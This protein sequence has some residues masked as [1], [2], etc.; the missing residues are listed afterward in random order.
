MCFQQL[1]FRRI[2]ESLAQRFQLVAHQ[3]NK[4][5]KRKTFLTFIVHRYIYL[6]CGGSKTRMWNI[7]V[8]FTYVAIWHDLNLNLLLWAW[9]ICFCLA[10][11][12]FVKN[13]VK[14]PKF[15]KYTQTHYWKYICAVAGG[16]YNMW[17]QF[18]NTIGFGMGYQTFLFFIS[19]A[20]SSLEGVIDILG[21]L[22]ILSLLCLKVLELRERDNKNY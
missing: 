4:T 5:S 16:F 2:L 6:P 8:V 22:L 19:K 17:L 21:S 12:I 20:F 7:W 18:T 10:P 3:V 15:N 1:Q 11:E 9:G 13:Y 14:K